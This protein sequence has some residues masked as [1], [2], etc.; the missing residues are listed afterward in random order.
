M[1]GPSGF[2]PPIFGLTGRRVKPDYTTAPYKFYIITEKVPFVKEFREASEKS[3]QS[4]LIT[5]IFK[6][7]Y[8]D[9]LT[10]N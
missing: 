3:P 4:P 7:D 8:T 9:F 2:E 6:N 10:N 1:A 5:Q